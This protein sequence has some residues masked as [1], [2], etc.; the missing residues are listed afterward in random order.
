MYNNFQFKICQFFL[1]T[2]EQK[3]LFVFLGN[4]RG[5]KRS[6]IQK[7]LLRFL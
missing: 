2:F 1:Y 3:N 5:K 4:T 6:S 7:M